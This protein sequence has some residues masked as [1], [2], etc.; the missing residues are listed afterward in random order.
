MKL[1]LT[2][3]KLKQII[4]EELGKVLLQEMRPGYYIELMDGIYNDEPYATEE[5]AEAGIP[6]YLRDEYPSPKIIKID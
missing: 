1:T 5:E 4:K 6:E 2:K 3:E